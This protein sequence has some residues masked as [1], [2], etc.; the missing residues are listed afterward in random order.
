MFNAFRFTV[1]PALLIIAVGWILYW[2]FE[3]TVTPVQE[4]FMATVHMVFSLFICVKLIVPLVIDDKTPYFIVAL[5]ITISAVFLWGFPQYST[6][7]IT[8]TY[9][10]PKELLPYIAKG[11]E[12][13]TKFWLLAIWYMICCYAVLLFVDSLDP[14]YLLKH[15]EIID[16][17]HT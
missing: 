4:V 9:V 8:A 2:V 16:E 11:F 7:S 12:E 6:E 15:P 17:R 5:L 10:G 3:G 13:A 1:L 14:S